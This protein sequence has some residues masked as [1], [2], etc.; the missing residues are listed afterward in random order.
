MASVMTGTPL[1]FWLLSLCLI[2]ILPR[3]WQA[4][5]LKRP[6]AYRDESS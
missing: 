6:A 3:W 1:S 5:I 2:V 4:L